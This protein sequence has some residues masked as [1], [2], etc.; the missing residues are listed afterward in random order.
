MT[1]KVKLR[2]SELRDIV[3]PGRYYPKLLLL[4]CATLLLIMFTWLPRAADDKQP[5]GPLPYVWAANQS[6]E[7][8]VWVRPREKTELISPQMCDPSISGSFPYLLIVVCSAIP[9]FDARMA[10]RSSW[11][12][13]EDLVPGIQIIFLVGT[14]E[15]TW[16][17][18][19]LPELEK[20]AEMY[21]DILQE[22]FID[23]YANLTI[24]SLMMLKWFNK[25]CDLGSKKRVEYL[26][27]TDDDM[28]INLAK[29]N[30]VVR[31]NRKPTLLMGSLICN[32]VP[33]KDPHNKY[34]VPQY[35]FSE[36]KYPNYLSG[37][38]YVMHRE[39]AKR[40]Y[41]TALETP[42]FHMEDIYLTGITSR[43]LGLRPQD[44]IGFS[45]VKR[46]MNNTCLISQIVTAHQ[47]KPEQMLQVYG[48]LQ[49]DKVKKCAVLKPKLLRPHGPNRCMWSKKFYSTKIGR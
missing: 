13:Q 10:I 2:G 42:I 35:M 47:V 23:S 9:N 27:K 12:K 31:E 11:G 15:N 4:L 34:Y 26:M 45:Y 28:F 39:T 5:H 3:S 16:N 21:N 37:T 49:S 29:L 43:K 44:N 8:A 7:A 18:T 1:S 6:R 25:T 46:N 22:D 36:K 30:T 20:E 33:I 38:G 41:E 19:D 24:K 17:S 48:A 14:V 32:A 40:I